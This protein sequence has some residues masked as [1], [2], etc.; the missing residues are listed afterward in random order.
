LDLQMSSICE[1][2]AAPASSMSRREGDSFNRAAAR[3]SSS[4]HCSDSSGLAGSAA[5]GMAFASPWKTLT[6]AWKLCVKR[7][8]S[9]I[10]WRIEITKT[11]GT[12]AAVVAGPLPTGSLSAIRGNF[13][14][15]LRR[16]VPD[17]VGAHEFVCSTSG[18]VSP[19]A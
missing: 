6:N 14:A 2:V 11:S 12:A 17:A 4:R 19:G 8:F 1:M 3:R 18:G 15:H 9:S 13:S 10:L 7:S 16:A 5:L